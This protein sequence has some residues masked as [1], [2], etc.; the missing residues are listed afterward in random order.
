MIEQTF[1]LTPEQAQEMERAYR[2]VRRSVDARQRRL[3]VLLSL[4]CDEHGQLV[5]RDAAIPLYEPP[6]FQDVH[7]D[8]KGEVM[9][10]GTGPA[11][12]FAALR[13]LQDGY[14]PVLIER[15]K[16]VSDRKLDIARLN[17]NEGLDSESNYCF[18]E[19]GAGTFSDGKLFSRSKKRGEMQRVMEW[20]HHFGAADTVLYETHAHIG[21]D[22]LPAI[23]RNMRETIVACGGEVR[24]STLLDLPLW[25]E[26]NRKRIPT[27][28][29]IGHSAHDT[30]RLLCRE[31]VR[32]SAKGCAMGVRVEHPQTLIDRLMYH[33]RDASQE[34]VERTVG[35]VG[36][37]SY[38]LVTQ[39]RTD[40]SSA[41]TRG[42][43]SFCMC[44]GG[45]IV[46]AGT[47]V[48]GCVVNGMSNSMRNSPYANSGIVVSLQPADYAPYAKEG[49]L[50]GLCFQEELEHLAASHGR[51]PS[52]A[53]AQRLTDF[54]DGR[55][56]ADL[57]ACSY[58]PGIVPSR[59]DEWLPAPIG[60]SLRQGF[61]DFGR[62]YPGY[63]TREAVVV[64]VES[65]SSSPVRIDRDRDTLRSLSHPWLYPAGEGAGYAG[66]IT[67]S[68][69]DGIR[70]A[71]SIIADGSL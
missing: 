17:R 33:L 41:Q 8:S 58:L 40:K 42:V 4:L 24:F 6:R 20:F 25:N 53:P 54:V 29:A 56:S 21:S 28:L 50:A 65:R 9:I 51:L 26:L 19:G 15:G 11:G 27:I 48:N 38:S 60:T 61:R 37:A 31:G 30:Y 39:V 64:G 22:R 43:Y 2:V 36:H 59:L 70:A 47:E 1:I 45:H 16:P 5:A 62:K 32:M 71:E 7:T 10:V 67:S 63:L 34:E 68:A 35:L 49:A 13:L 55:S 52:V 69:L 23:I 44:P 57:P 14:K 18:G 66:G 12:L 3:H 46:P